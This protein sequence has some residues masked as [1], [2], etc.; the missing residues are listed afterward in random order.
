MDV[1]TASPSPSALAELAR[2]IDRPLVLVGMMGCG[3]TTLGRKLAHVLGLPF[4]DADE[5]IERAAQMS[6]GEIFAAFGEDGFRDGERRV[7][8]RLIGEAGGRMVI[9]LGGGAFA[10]P[11]TRALILDRALA[12]WLDCDVDTL[13]ER[14]S[15]KDTRPLL[16]QGDPRATLTR[17]SAERRPAYAQAPIRVASG[18][19][20]QHRTLNAILHTLAARP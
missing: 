5:E 10:D 12:I 15:R 19:G 3:K 11:R 13:M 7:I 4:V 6:I 8:A 1:E 20:P 16:R 17:L 18:P 14:V 9:A 2:R